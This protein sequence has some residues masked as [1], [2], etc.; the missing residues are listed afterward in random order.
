LTGKSQF[1]GFEEWSEDDALA[2]IGAG[3]APYHNTFRASNTGPS[4]QTSL[5]DQPRS[6]A[7]RILHTHDWH[8]P[9]PQA[10]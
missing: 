9:T 4:V 3:S 7:S 8:V 10:M 1:D 5:Y 2:P 6:L